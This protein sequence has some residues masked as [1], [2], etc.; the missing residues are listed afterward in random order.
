MARVDWT[1][2][3]PQ[4]LTIPGVMKLSTLADVQALMRHLPA[5]HAERPPWRHVVCGSRLVLPKHPTCQTL[6]AKECTP[7][8]GGH[9]GTGSNLLDCAERSSPETA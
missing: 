7:L 4:P 6:S 5:G 8:S 3:L 2:P 9:L 1:R